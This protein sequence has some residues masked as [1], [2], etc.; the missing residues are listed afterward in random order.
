MKKSLLQ[1][2]VVAFLAL[3]TTPLFSFTSFSHVPAPPKWEKLGERKINF[4][5]DRDE[6]PVGSFEG[7]FDALQVKVRFGSINM[8]KMVVY[9]GNGETKEIELRDNFTA[10]SSSR[11][12]DLPGN[13]RII[14]KVVFWYDTK[15]RSRV[16]AR[17]ELWGR[18]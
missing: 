6:M 12:I 7:F 18:H 1:P 2:L 9:F 16:R 11:V 14:T 13:N 8:Y 17:I 15:N 10:G 3:I 4:A 5:L